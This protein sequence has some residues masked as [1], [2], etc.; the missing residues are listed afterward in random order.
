MRIAVANMLYKFGI[1]A[2]VKGYRYLACAIELVQ[3]DASLAKCMTTYVY[4]AIAESF[5]AT[6]S[7]VERDI[8]YAVELA[9]VNTPPEV[10]KETFGASIPPHKNKATNAQFIATLAEHLSRVAK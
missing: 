9:F 2:N 1:P 3:N 4:P 8:R 10:I 6:K 5:G 7:S